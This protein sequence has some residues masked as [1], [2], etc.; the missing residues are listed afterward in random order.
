[1]YNNTQQPLIQHDTQ[2]SRI[3]EEDDVDCSI[4]ISG[5]I[6]IPA[7]NIYDICRPIEDDYFYWLACDK[8]KDDD[9]YYWNYDDNYYDPCRSM[10][11]PSPT[12]KPSR[13]PTKRPTKEPSKRPTKIPSLKPSNRPSKR[14]VIT[15]RPTRSPTFKPSEIP[16]KIPIFSPT[17]KP[18]KIPSESP[19][20][21][22]TTESPTIKTTFES[23]TFKPTSQITASPT[24]RPSRIPTKTPTTRPSKSP[25]N[26]PTIQ[27]ATITYITDTPT[28]Q[29]STP[30][31]TLVP[32]TNRLFIQSISPQPTWKG[33]TWD[34]SDY[35]DFFE[36]ENKTELQEVRNVSCNDESSSTESSLNGLSFII[37][38]LQT[39]SVKFI[40]SIEIG[41][42]DS[43]QETIWNTYENNNY[44]SIIKK[45]ESHI[46]EELGDNLLY[47]RN[48]KRRKEV[49]NSRSDF[50][51]RRSLSS[52]VANERKHI[53]S[54]QRIKD[55]ALN[56]QEEKYPFIVSSI[57]SLSMDKVSQTST[58][59]LTL[60]GSSLCIVVDGMMELSYII[61]DERI[62]SSASRKERQSYAT[63]VLEYNMRFT[64]MSIMEDYDLYLTASDAGQ[65]RPPIKDVTKLKYIGPA[66]EEPTEKS[67]TSTP[68]GTS[69]I[70]GTDIDQNSSQTTGD[71]SRITMPLLA[72]IVL[73]IL[74]TSIGIFIQKYRGRKYKTKRKAALKKKK[75]NNKDND[76]AEEKNVS[77]NSPIPSVPDDAPSKKLGYISY[78]DDET[79]AIM[80]V[81]VACSL[82]VISERSDEDTTHG[83]RISSAA[84]AVLRSSRSSRSICSSV[85]SS[86]DFDATSTI[87]SVE[88]RSS[89][90]SSEIVDREFC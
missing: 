12:A 58:C 48:Y 80:L 69:G 2:S 81:D 11:R 51:M 53:F 28:I 57:A 23:L 74:I 34:S 71:I 25:T 60:E 33:I 65:Q 36:V 17:I 26:M 18:T 49:E 89:C 70:S 73:G 7:S 82:S 20:I 72:M 87:N 39:L 8:L 6:P 13:R 32:S 47:C 3:L 5:A 43:S 83:G 52:F 22:P 56:D 66:F 30:S 44:L 55:R 54:D 42:P 41:G 40:Y 29:L 90:T 24:S 9:D 27:P 76:A 77:K 10:Y 62:N 85:L 4:Y 64:I 84:S 21:K 59:H 35:H 50:F 38:N 45:V 16:T 86:S 67:D 63:E 46:L 19:I 1:M 37:D 31:S 79:R 15:K 61:V 14:P 75:K 88:I 68:L 78:Y